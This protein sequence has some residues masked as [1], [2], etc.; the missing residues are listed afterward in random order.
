MPK[1]RKKNNKSLN[2]NSNEQGANI[3]PGEDQYLLG[4]DDAEKLEKEKPG[5]ARTFFKFL[6]LFKGITIQNT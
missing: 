4:W 2:I 1:K 3:P 6:S 5:M